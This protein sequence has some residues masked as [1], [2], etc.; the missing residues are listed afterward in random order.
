MTVLLPLTGPNPVPLDEPATPVDVPAPPIFL[1]E[2]LYPL[3]LKARVDCQP[4]RRLLLAV[5]TLLLAVP[6]AFNVALAP[7]LTT[8]NKLDPKG[9]PSSHSPMAVSLVFPLISSEAMEPALPVI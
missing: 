8:E 2:A 6:L 9:I 7:V 3:L 1:D 4:N 5:P